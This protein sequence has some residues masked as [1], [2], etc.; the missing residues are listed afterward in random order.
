M[1]IS[2]D[3]GRRVFALQIAG[4]IYRYHSGAGVAG[5]NSTI[6]TSI[7]YIDTEGII[8]ISSFGGSVDP[9]GGVGTYEP[10]TV[11]L[12]INKKGSSS[13]AG[14]IFGR[15]GARSITPS[16]RITQNVTRT[17]TEI[18]IDTD[19]TSL[20][21]PRLFHIGAETI[22]AGGALSNKLTSITR[23]IDNTPRQ[24]HS[25]DLEGSYT[26]EIVDQITTFRGRR[27]KLLCAHQYPDDTL[28]N[29]SEILNGF[30]ESTPTIENGDSVSISL[31]PLV[32]L[33]DTVIVDKGLG[34]SFLLQGYH[35]FSQR[36][37]VLEYC[38]EITG[39]GAGNVLEFEP[40]TNSTITANTLT[41]YT[42]NHLI[43]ENFDTTLQTGLD[44]NDDA[45]DF[46]HPRFPLF[47]TFLRN[48][49]YPTSITKSINT[50]D[51][52]FIYTMALDSSATTASASEIILAGEVYLHGEPE[53]KQFTFD[54][55]LEWPKAINDTLINSGPS[56]MAG[57]DGG[58]LQW[59][60]SPENE[61]IASALYEGQTASN[62]LLYNDEAA[63]NNYYDVI[64]RAR[65]YTAEG[66]RIAVS[67]ESRL[68][69]PIDLG[70]DDQ[71]LFDDNRPHYIE[72]YLKKIEISSL[73]PSSVDQLKDVAKAFY[74][75]GDRRLLVENSLGLPTSQQII[76]SNVVTFDLVI[77][78]YDRNTQS[79]KQQVLQ[80]THETVATFSSANVGYYIHLNPNQVLTENISFGD[81]SEGDRALIT[82]GGR[83]N[84]ERPATAIL[85]LLCSGGGAQVNN[86]YDVFSVGCNLA[87]TNIDEDS[88]LSADA[89]SPFSVS[90]QF[91]GVDAD[92]REI[93]DS[94]LKLIGAVMIMR[95]DG[96]TSKIA[97]VP[98]GGDRAPDVAG[99]IS[100]Q[101]WLA[102]PPPHWDSYEDIVTQIKYE[103][104][105]DPLEDKY[106]SEVIFNNQ[107]AINRFSGER[108]Q[109]TISLAG[110]SSAQF[111][112][113]AGDIF[114]E[115]LP[116]S[117]RIFRLLSNPLRVWRGSIGTGKSSLFDLGT[118]IECSSPHLR[119]YSDNY[120][121]TEGV[122]MIRSIRQELMSEGCDLEIINTGLQV[123]AW[124]ASAE[125]EVVDSSTVVTIFLDIYSSNN[126]DNIYF[127]A[128]DLVDYL[129]LGDQDNALIG[130][131][132]QSIVN[133]TITFTSAHGITAAYGTL[134]PTT[135]ANASTHHQNDAY[136]ANNSDIINTTI[137][138]QEYN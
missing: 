30:I 96:S 19:L 75:L 79:T 86:K 17:D 27:A 12:G 95:R 37:N 138:A 20:S 43:L 21:Y 117:S 7:N 81:W 36:N 50:A 60:L 24:A 51:A 70:T 101:H 136:L 45:E 85:K 72:G 110:V 102:D 106:R 29:W 121:V 68:W 78:Y 61:I 126:T 58:F 93:I 122:G 132:I 55:L 31:V 135:F 83:F 23:S 3:A 89:A 38:T 54:G 4:C 47:T 107:E 42:A 108:S 111:G 113:G 137:A 76:N 1:S 52:R 26:P 77:T 46:T 84:N 63:L 57:I 14:V 128:G 127:K 134:E 62:L 34:Q 11:T 125:V 94:L 98:I 56:S 48:K 90:G 28:S 10:I 129:P 13:D 66:S 49:I 87:L 115:F 25:I 130:L 35:Y 131:E 22:R 6:A 65:A 97:L 59:R 2:S 8:A 104:D 64:W 118:Y 32:A 103:Y 92:I 120:G 71:A 39:R 91:A 124:N 73:Q 74:Q 82:R 99:S 9:S 133:N 88:F 18:F 69:Y 5:L 109:I 119:D 41:V 53:L 80:A 40:T 44:S 16:A 114:A 33:I 67:K 100:A 123:V 15:C 105:Y 116:T 112:R